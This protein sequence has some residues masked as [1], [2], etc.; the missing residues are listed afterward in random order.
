MKTADRNADKRGV[1][2]VSLLG[3][4]LLI[5]AGAAM[6]LSYRGVLHLGMF[7]PIA[8][9]IGSFIGAIFFIGGLLD[10]CGYGRITGE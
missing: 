4:M 1:L 5:A 8:I 10:Y 6:V 7:A 2:V 3:A 9:I